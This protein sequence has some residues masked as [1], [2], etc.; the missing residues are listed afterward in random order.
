MQNTLKPEK[1]K[2]KRRW[3]KKD[4]TKKGDADKISLED[5]EVIIKKEKKHKKWF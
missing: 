3:L 2:D 1:K 5:S 4:K